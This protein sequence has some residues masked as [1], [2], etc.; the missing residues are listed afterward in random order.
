MCV[1]MMKGVCYTCMT[2]TKVSDDFLEQGN[3]GT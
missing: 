3:K 1:T 2:M